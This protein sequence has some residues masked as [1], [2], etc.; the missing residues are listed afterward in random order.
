MQISRPVQ[1]IKTAG[2]LGGGSVLFAIALFAVAIYEHVK[3]ADVQSSWLIALGVVFYSFGAYMAWNRERD[4][5]EEEKTRQERPHFAINIETGTFKYR[6]EDKCSE[7]I[8][9]AL[10]VNQGS[11]S[12]AAGWKVSYECRGNIEPMAVSYLGPLVKELPMLD[13]VLDISNDD[14]ISTKTLTDQIP[15]GGAQ[16]GRIICTIA[17]DRTEEW[18]SQPAPTVTLTCLDYLCTPYSAIYQRGASNPYLAFYPSER[19]RFAEPPGDP[20]N[21][22]ALQK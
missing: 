11:P 5:Y 3:D 12:I 1:F 10:I 14:L 6:S 9:A 20:S 2:L 15:R 19:V 16:H 13:G 22:P 21:A 7:V 8:L 4:A 17:G 18:N